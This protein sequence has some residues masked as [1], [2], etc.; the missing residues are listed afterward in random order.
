[1][2]VATQEIIKKKTVSLYWVALTS[3]D[4]SGKDIWP[5]LFTSLAPNIIYAFVPG[6]I[7]LNWSLSNS[8]RSVNAASVLTPQHNQSCRSLRCVNFTSKIEHWTLGIWQKGV[9]D[10]S[11]WYI[12]HNT[13]TGYYSCFSHSWLPH[14]IKLLSTTSQELNLRR[15]ADPVLLM[16][17]NSVTA[18]IEG[19][20][21]EAVW[22]LWSCSL[23]HN[24]TCSGI[25]QP[26][27]R[28]LEFPRGKQ[29]LSLCLGYFNDSIWS[30]ATTAACAARVSGLTCHEQVGERLP[31]TT[32][33]SRCSY[34]GPL[35]TL[36]VCSCQSKDFRSVISTPRQESW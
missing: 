5:N 9:K 30:W 24:A 28:V 6:L 17:K 2:Q 11:S 19:T 8:T 13:L 36:P 3:L 34:G 27:K 33:V 14:V 29:N 15:I 20:A 4:A 18:L 31:T 1:M 12:C 7:K 23:A 26:I 35:S 32:A 16:T 22:L 25:D 21:C 10:A